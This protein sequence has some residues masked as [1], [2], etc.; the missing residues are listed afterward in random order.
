MSK[1]FAE[2]FNSSSVEKSGKKYTSQEIIKGVSCFHDFISKGEKT[3]ID[4]FTKH[5]LWSSLILCQHYIYSVKLLTIDDIR[6][7]L[8]LQLNPDSLK[9]QEKEAYFWLLEAMNTRPEVN[10]LVEAL[11]HFLENNQDVYLRGVQESKKSF[12]DYVGFFSSTFFVMASA[13]VSLLLLP[14]LLNVGL[15]FIALLAIGFFGSRFFKKK[16]KESFQKTVKNKIIEIDN[17]EVGG[18]SKKVLDL[19]NAINSAKFSQY[20]EL[21]DL[22]GKLKNATKRF[23]ALHQKNPSNWEMYFQV[24]RVWKDSIPSIID[25]DFEDSQTRAYVKGVLE[26]ILFIVNRDLQDLLKNE[27]NG[28]KV[29]HQFWASRVEE[30]QNEDKI[31]V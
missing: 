11:L 10:N 23:A 22:F 3:G 1:D 26:K 25:Y 21:N 18:E 16:K 27:L 5:W 2:N 29:E 17:I 19:M 7:I 31:N 30:K 12:S 20:P 28:L 13:G 4:N 24:E 6:Q 14:S 15:A 9:A 8:T